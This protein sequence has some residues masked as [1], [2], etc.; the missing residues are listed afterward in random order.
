M[1]KYKIIFKNIEAP[2]MDLTFNYGKTKYHLEDGKEY[3]LSQEVIVHLNDLAYPDPVFKQNNDGQLVLDA[4]RKK[5]RF[6][7]QLVNPFPVKK[8]KQIAQ[9]EIVLEEKE[10]EEEIVAVPKL[11]KKLAFSK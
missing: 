6:N 3:D 1:E 9:K 10:P 11:K 7:C 4:S 5:Y 2:G 8:E